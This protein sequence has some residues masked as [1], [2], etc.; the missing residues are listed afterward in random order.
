MNPLCYQHPMTDTN[1]DH[2]RPPRGARARDDRRPAKGGRPFDKASGKPP[3]KAPGRFPGKPGG[4]GPGKPRF[5]TGPARSG[6]DGAPRDPGRRVARPAASDAQPVVEAVP[7]EER[8]AKVI[9]RAGVASRRDAE[10]MIEAGRVTLNGAP[11]TSPAINVGPNDVITVD[12]EALPSR[13]RTRLWLFHKPRGLVTT[14]RDPEGRP[15]VFDSLPEEMPR[16]VAIGR[17]D[18]NTEGLL[19]LTNDGGLAKVV[20][21]PETGWT[22]RYRARARGEVTQADLDRLRKGIT[23]DGMEYGPVEA[24]LDRVQG[25]NSWISIS[26]REG[27]N[28]EVKRIL[29]HLG[30]QVNRLIRLSFGPF[31]LGELESGLVEEIRTKVLK[32]QLGE[33][34]AAEAGADFESPVRT[35]IA[36]F[37]KPAQLQARPP[38]SRNAALRG[39]Q[40]RPE[41][42]PRPDFDRPPRAA[43]FERG[44]RRSARPKEQREERPRDLVWRADDDARPSRPPRRDRR[45]DP[46][47]ERAASASKPRSRAK[48][49]EGGEG[50]RVLVERIV[51]PPREERRPR[52]ENVDRR[53]W[54][55]EASDRSEGGFRGGG[56]GRGAP[57]APRGGFGGRP[58]PGR[59]AGGG[60]RPSPGDRPRPGGRPGPRP[61]RS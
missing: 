44:D 28:R 50:R 24:V 8:I 25:D 34:L 53:R 43:P 33:S 22:R 6:P 27:K 30:L 14:F 19:L 20:A 46:K 37:G 38:R 32:E 15:T 4:K 21:H 56:K 26:L 42:P 31:Q 40:G 57:A 7:S 16:V 29:E 3:G 9:A 49:I 1:D 47:A 39:E 41:R 18:I 13:E 45:E 55:D 54:K 10:A 59:P 60:K 12:G 61:P 2:P 35:P 52:A 23:I 17:L 36:P 5:G 11:L 58:G 51:A 48:P